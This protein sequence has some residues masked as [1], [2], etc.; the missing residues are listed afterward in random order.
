MEHT[1]DINQHVLSEMNERLN[2][3]PFH[4]S[5]TGGLG[6]VKQLV[7][8][9]LVHESGRSAAWGSDLAESRPGAV[10]P[11]SPGWSWGSRRLHSSGNS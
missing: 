6:E 9:H 4:S 1:A 8:H 3:F 11:V 7:R 5:G 2:E 10:L